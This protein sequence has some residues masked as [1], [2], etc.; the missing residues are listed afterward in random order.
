MNENLMSNA[1]E[2]FKSFVEFYR[3]SSESWTSLPSNTSLRTR[4]AAAADCFATSTWIG[5]CGLNVKIKT[6]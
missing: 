3:L 2:I 6:K 4:M 1:L 5:S